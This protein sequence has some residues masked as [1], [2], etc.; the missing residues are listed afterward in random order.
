[1]S[2]DEAKAALD[3]LHASIATI[4]DSDAW[5]AHLAVQARFH[6]YSPLNIMWM[7]CQWEGRRAENPDLA[8]FSQPAAFSAWKDLGRHVRKGEKALSV[9]AAISIRSRI[10]D[11]VMFLPQAANGLAGLS[12]PPIASR[13]IWRFSTNLQ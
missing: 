12:L 8:E 2:T 9:L 4:T 1:M 6:D 5:R 7:W 10:G 11:N 13:T 3:T